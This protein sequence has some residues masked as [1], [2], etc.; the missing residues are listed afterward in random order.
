MTFH[1]AHSSTLSAEEA[2]ISAA[3]GYIENNRVMAMSRAMGDSELKQQY[4]ELPP[5]QRILI[6]DPDV[7][8]YQLTEEDEFLVLICDSPYHTAFCSPPTLSVGRRYV[9]LPVVA[10]CRQHGPDF[11]DAPEG[12]RGNL[13]LPHSST[14]GRPTSGTTT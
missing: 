4:S 11:S 1:A 10:R 6:C 5:E 9:G 12:L 13:R 3:G 2:P 7:M 8:Q 14:I